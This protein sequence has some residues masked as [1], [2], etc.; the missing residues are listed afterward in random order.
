MALDFEGFL[1]YGERKKKQEEEQLAIQQAKEKLQKRVVL[2]IQ[3]FREELDL[4][5]DKKIEM[6]IVGWDVHFSNEEYDKLKEELGA[7]RIINDNR[8]CWEDLATER[9]IILNTT[10]LEKRYTKEQIEQ[11]KKEL[12]NNNN[13]LGVV[14]G[15]IAIICGALTLILNEGDYHWSYK[16]KEPKHTKFLQKENIIIHFNF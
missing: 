4:K 12:L 8:V 13:C 15:Q 2:A 7:E 14:D 16:F 1:T 9:N 6:R 10:E 5:D 3:N 11:A